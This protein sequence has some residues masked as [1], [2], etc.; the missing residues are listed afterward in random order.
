MLKEGYITLTVDQPPTYSFSKQDALTA[1]QI[2]RPQTT[3][4]DMIHTFHVWFTI[5]VRDNIT[6]FKEYGNG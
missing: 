3:R 6:D 2:L 1:V 5:D 4:P